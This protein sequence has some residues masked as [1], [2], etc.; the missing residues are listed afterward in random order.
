MKI[1]IIDLGSNS[2]RMTVWQCENA[3]TKVI[4]NGRKYVRLSEGLAEDNLLKKEPTE[5]TLRALLEFKSIADSLSCD[6]IRAVATEAMRRAENGAEFAERIKSECG[7][8][9]EILSGADESRYDFYASVDLID[10]PSLIMDVGGGSLELISCTAD[11]LLSHT[12]LPYGA[13]VMTDRFGDDFFALTEFFTRRF[14]ELDMLKKVENPDIIGLGGSIRALFDFSLKK[15]QGI[16]M[17]SEMLCSEAERVASMTCAE[18]EK[19][20]AFSE[21]ADVIKAGLAP[22]YALSRLVNSEKITLN[23][24]G[25]REGVLFECLK[26]KS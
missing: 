4:Y 10:A 12:C 14:S 24:R 19:I 13:V 8:D 26:L 15:E 5:R 18:L 20:E 21:R 25:V 1:A 7:I 9:I 11:S 17:S 16:S 6:R 2:V 22:F 23:N 3:K